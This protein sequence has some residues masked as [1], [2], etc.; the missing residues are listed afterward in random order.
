MSHFSNSIEEWFEANKHRQFFLSRLDSNLLLK[1][2]DFG[3]SRN[4]E[5]KEYYRIEEGT[6]E[7]PI[8]WMS[9]E[10][11]DK[12]VFTTKSDVVGSI[13][14]QLPSADISILF[15]LWFVFQWSYGVLLWEIFNFACLPYKGKNNIAVMDC[16][17][18]G[19]ILPQP[20]EA[21]QEM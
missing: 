7:L 13:S 19:T 12:N 2:S 20:P 14:L 18:K 9:P 21:P 15:G 10:S 11:V 6:Q 4:V 1:I 17:K 5:E 16:I 8:R 3:L